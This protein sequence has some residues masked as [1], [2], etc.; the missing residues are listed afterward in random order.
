M[1]KNSEKLVTST[2]IGHREGHHFGHHFVC[3]RLK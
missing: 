3:N 2:K 1:V